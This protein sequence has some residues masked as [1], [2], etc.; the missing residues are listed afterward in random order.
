MNPELVGETV[1]SDIEC[2]G[3]ES[4]TLNTVTVTGTGNLRAVA[5]AVRI[6]TSTSW[7]KIEGTGRFRVNA[8]EEGS[9]TT[10]DSVY[11]ASCVRSPCH[12]VIP[13]LEQTGFF[14][15]T[16]TAFVCFP[17]DYLFDLGDNAS[18]NFFQYYSISGMDITLQR[19]QVLDV[20]AYLNTL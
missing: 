12:G 17:D 13:G 1:S 20:I 7:F 3:S 4:V 14:R 16:C 19:Q 5:P 8:L 9:P 6:D 10:G 2:R 15:S 18:L 11:T